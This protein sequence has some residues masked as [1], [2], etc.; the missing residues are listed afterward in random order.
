MP[1]HPELQ[2]TVFLIVF[3]IVAAVFCWKEWPVAVRLWN[4]WPGKALHLVVAFVGLVL[5]AKIV[6]KATGLGA[7]DFEFTVAA[8]TPFA[9]AGLWSILINAA[10]GALTI[11]LFVKMGWRNWAKKQNSFRLTLEYANAASAFALFIFS[12][13]VSITLLMAVVKPPAV[14]RW[15]ACFLDMHLMPAMPGVPAELP[16]AFVGDGVVVT[17]KVNGFDCVIDAVSAETTSVRVL[18]D[19]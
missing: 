9:I 15:A 10:S 16:A 3:A 2:R 7:R 12:M 11:A 17:G 13:S 1:L 6:A 18:P 8:V 4:S 14:V 19:P 5:A